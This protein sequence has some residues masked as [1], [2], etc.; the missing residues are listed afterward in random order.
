VVV[1]R[2]REGYD[3]RYGLER[4]WVTLGGRLAGKLNIRV[5]EGDDLRP[6]S[7]TSRLGAFLTSAG[8]AAYAGAVAGGGFPSCAGLSADR[9]AAVAHLQRL[10]PTIVERTR[11]GATTP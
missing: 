3:L 5:G 7:A 1:E 10:L 8:G 9:A 11:G 6:E 4:D 2:W